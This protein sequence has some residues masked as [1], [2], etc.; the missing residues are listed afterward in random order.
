MGI[1]H[2]KWFIVNI[3]DKGWKAVQQS[4][5][6]NDTNNKD[7]SMNQGLKVVGVGYGRTGTYSLALALDELGFPVLVSRFYF[8]VYIICFWGYSNNIY[9]IES[10]SAYTTFI[11]KRRDI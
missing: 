9:H 5:T 10:S 1:G 4:Y 11:R 6:D 2:P 7:S 3:I 8:E